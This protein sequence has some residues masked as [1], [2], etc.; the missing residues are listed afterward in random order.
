MYFVIFT[1]RVLIHSGAYLY[2]EVLE[3]VYQRGK[4][5][6][7]NKPHCIFTRDARRIT[8]EP[9]KK[10]LILKHTRLEIGSLSVK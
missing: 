6:S 3:L 4:E 7:S 8:T 1:L 5:I 10:L 9:A 2:S